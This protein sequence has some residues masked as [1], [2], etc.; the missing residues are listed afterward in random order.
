MTA[1]DIAQIDSVRRTHLAHV[2]LADADRRILASAETARHV[3]FRPGESVVLRY[4]HTTKA[5]GSPARRVGNVDCPIRRD[6]DVTV[7]SSGALCRVKDR[8]AGT[9]RD[10]AVIAAC[11]LS[12]GNDVL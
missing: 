3:V 10:S 12:F 9:E 4:R 11:A 1:V 7:D 6:F 2:V 8:H 5:R